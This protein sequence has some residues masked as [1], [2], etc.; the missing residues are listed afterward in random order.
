MSGVGEAGWGGAGRYLAA[1]KA[2]NDRAL[3]GHV[4]SRL[5]HS[6]PAQSSARP[7]RVL[8]IGAGIGT[9]VERLIERD[10]LW[11]AHYT[12]VD[13]DPARG[14]VGNSRAGRHLLSH[15]RRHGATV[16]AVGASDWIVHP[17]PVGGYPADEAWFLRTVVDTIGSAVAGS[18]ALDADRLG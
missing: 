18:P 12:A 1:K 7:L 10:V 2:V 14:H 8:E 16:L 5:L 9:M 4:W 15:L 11:H 13:A 6:L 3:N 17:D